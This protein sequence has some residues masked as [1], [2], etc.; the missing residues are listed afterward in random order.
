MVDSAFVVRSPGFQLNLAVAKNH[1]S[2]LSST[3]AWMQLEKAKLNASATCR[4]S[5]ALAKHDVV[6]KRK[7]VEKDGSF[8]WCSIHFN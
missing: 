7:A 6:V 1:Y 8:G 4:R 3:K 5:W 2:H